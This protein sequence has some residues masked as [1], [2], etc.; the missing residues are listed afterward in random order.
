MH[1]DKGL[2]TKQNKGQLVTNVAVAQPLQKINNLHANIKTGTIVYHS[3][4][5]E[6]RVKVFNQKK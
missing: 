1:R 6:F 2:L 4:S 3:G 5:D